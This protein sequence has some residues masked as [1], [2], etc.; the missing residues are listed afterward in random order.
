MFTISPSGKCQSTVAGSAVL[1]KALYL[2]IVF[3]QVQRQISL[4]SFLMLHYILI[5]L[6]FI[7]TAAS[8][9]KQLVLSS[10]PAMVYN[11]PRELYNS[12]TE[13]AGLWRP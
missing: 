12:G 2:K 1:I 13:P 6:L 8:Q 10:Y 5:L 4:R 9:L 7:P 11:I 3:L